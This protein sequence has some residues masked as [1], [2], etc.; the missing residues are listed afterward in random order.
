M[1]L[2]GHTERMKMRGRA[3][4]RSTLGYFLS[5][6]FEIAHPWAVQNR[7]PRASGAGSGWLFGVCRLPLP[8]GDAGLMQAIRLAA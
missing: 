7:T 8:G 4:P 6:H 1:A 2:T 3:N 5:G